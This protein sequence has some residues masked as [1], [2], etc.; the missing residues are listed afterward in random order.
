MH[1][2]S[3]RPGQLPALFA[4]YP[5]YTSS[6]TRRLNDVRGL[7]F[8]LRTTGTGSQPDVTVAVMM[9]STGI[10]LLGFAPALT[11]Y[12]L[13][14]CFKNSQKSPRGSVLEAVAP[15]RKEGTCFGSLAGVQTARRSSRCEQPMASRHYCK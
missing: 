12:F 2:H 9:I 11:D 1:A 6:T 14:R 10:A 5:E 8:Y 3:R 4:R 13:E 7:R 15:P